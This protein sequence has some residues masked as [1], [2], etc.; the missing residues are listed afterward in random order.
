MWQKENQK[1][2][3]GRFTSAETGKGRQVRH[4]ASEAVEGKPWAFRAIDVACG[5]APLKT[6]RCATSA[7]QYKQE[8]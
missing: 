5:N 8:R 1:E 4:V 7:W 3:K 6:C 2:G